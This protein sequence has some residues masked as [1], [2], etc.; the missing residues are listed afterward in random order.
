MGPQAAFDLLAMG[1]AFDAER[2]RQAGFVTRVVPSETIEAEAIAAAGR[3]RQAARGARPGTGLMR[4]D[5]AEILARVDEEAA[6]F[7]TRL[8]RWKRRPPSA[9]H[10]PQELT[11]LCISLT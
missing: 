2:A 3:S 9:L 6:L 4:G 11:I 8:A 7:A 5:P 10:G 1:T